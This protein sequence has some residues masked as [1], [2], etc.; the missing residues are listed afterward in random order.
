[1]NFGDAIEL[2]EL[3]QLR[4]SLRENRFIEQFHVGDVLEDF[5]YHFEIIG[6]YHDAPIDPEQITRPSVTLMAKELLPKHRMHDG[7][8]LNGWI[9]TELRK[10]LNTEVFDSLPDGLKTMIQPTKRFSMNCIGNKSI[11]EDKLFIPTESELFGSAIYSPAE[12]GER[13]SVFSNSNRRICYDENGNPACYWTSS[14]Y[15]G[16]STAFVSVSSYGHVGN[17][18]ASFALRAPFCFRISG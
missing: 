7:E 5:G 8:C 14:A 13:Y 6:Y 9:D 3:A 12:C 10:W 11:C 1:M 18:S 17:S 15:T 4:K 2:S 16:Y